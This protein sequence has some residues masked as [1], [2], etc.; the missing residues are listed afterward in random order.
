MVMPTFQTTIF[1]KPYRA[2]L[3]F[4]VVLMQKLI[5]AFILCIQAVFVTYE[6]THVGQFVQKN[7]DR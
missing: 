4:S 3:V 1:C 6:L 2:T 7:K 5:V